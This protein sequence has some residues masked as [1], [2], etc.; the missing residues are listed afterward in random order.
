MSDVTLQTERLLLRMPA[1]SDATAVFAY[2]SDPDVTKYLAFRTHTHRSEAEA[3]ISRCL[4]NAS[5]GSAYTWLIVHRGE[6]AP[7]GAIE[8]RVDGNFGDI[9]YVIRKPWWGKGIVPEALRAVT[10]FARNRLGLHELTGCCDCE[11]ERSARVFLK[12][13]FQEIDP[14]QN[15]LVHPQL[16]S[17]ARPTRRFQLSLA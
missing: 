13:G 12:C 11:N 9:G 16:G 6:A 8:I 1:M 10:T 7:I 15:T 3:F 4:A 17:I 5:T 14:Q 2:A